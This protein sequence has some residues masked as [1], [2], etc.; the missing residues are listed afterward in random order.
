MDR[1]NA[2]VARFNA[3]VRGGDWSEFMA[4]FAP[5]AAM[6]FG[7]APAGSFCGRDAIAQAYADHPPDDTMTVHAVT[8]SGDADRV[9]FGWGDGGGGTMDL[10]W[11]GDQ[12]AELCVTFDTTPPKAVP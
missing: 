9:R 5:G 8:T 1:V 10:L 7:G 12:L 11:Q 6:R 3:A 4:T 2:H